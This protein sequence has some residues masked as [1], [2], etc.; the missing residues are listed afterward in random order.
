[1][2]ESSEHPL[3]KSIIRYAEE[4]QLNL[5][6]AS[7]VETIIGYG[8][9]GTVDTQKVVIGNRDLMINELISTQDGDLLLTNTEQNIGSQ[10]WVAIDGQLV[11][12][13]IIADTL[14]V[15]SNSAI[16]LLQQA[17]ISTTMLSGDNEMVV[18]VMAKALQ[19]DHYYA[20]VKPEHKS[21]YIKDK[22]LLGS[23]VAM[24]G[25]GINDA[26]ALAQADI[27]IAMGS[28]TDV[29][30]ETANITLLRNDPRL[31]SAAMDISKL[32]W[33]KIQQNLFWAFIFNLIGLPLAATGYLSPEFAGAAMAFSS[34]AVLSNSLLIKRWK[35]K[36]VEA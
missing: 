7:Q 23:V 10:M 32:T 21:N 1:M 4:Q 24:V 6:A 2:Q 29:A 27:S 14:R 17:N 18:S 28:G 34:I 22:Q 12:L 3:A 5:L 15:E 36:F 16:N 8:I 25:D 26:P 31:V 11:G 33:R 30:M 19:V 20:Q 9:S 13:F 35:P